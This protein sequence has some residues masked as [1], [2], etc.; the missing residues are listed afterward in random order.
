MNWLLS[1]P[2]WGKRHTDLFFSGP[3]Q[4]IKAALAY[5]GIRYPRF[6]IYTDDPKRFRREMPQEARECRLEF[7]AVEPG[8][9]YERFGDAHRI[10]LEGAQPW[11]CVAL[12]CADMT[13]STEVFAACEARFLEGTRLIMA[14]ANRTVAPSPAPG[15][16]ARKLLAWSVRHLHPICRDLFWPHGR[17]AVPWSIYFRHARGIDLRAFHLHPIALVKK[18]NVTFVGLTSDADLCLSYS[19]AETHVVVDPDELGLAETSPLEKMNA[20]V[21]PLDIGRVLN[22]ATFSTV[23][24]HRWFFSQRIVLT[25]SG[26]TA[27]EPV[28]RAILE[29]LK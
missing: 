23:P 3:Y 5:A 8:Y 11:E 10:V 20:R 9:Y 29:R 15:Q 1:V 26:G 22:W 6:L 24:R 18:P 16:P 14:S 4:S 19:Q 17:G 7:R 25:G 13:L 27:D 21:Q 12:L 2:C 28:V